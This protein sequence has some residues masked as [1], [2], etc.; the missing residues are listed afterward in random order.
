MKYEGHADPETDPQDG[1]LGAGVTPQGCCLDGLQR[2]QPRGENLGRLSVLGWGRA[3]AE[4][5]GKAARGGGDRAQESR[6]G[7]QAAD[8]RSPPDGRG[9]N[10]AWGGRATKVGNQEM[11][12]EGAGVSGSEAETLLVRK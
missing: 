1:C 6:W 12:V 8:G 4:K 3:R 9:R 7:S 10:G 2:G 5:G 11:W